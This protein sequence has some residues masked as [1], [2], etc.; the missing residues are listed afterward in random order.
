[1]AIA[2]GA[3]DADALR[4]LADAVLDVEVVRLALEVRAG[5]PHAVRRAVELAA[6]VLAAAAEECASRSADGA[7][8]SV[9]DTTGT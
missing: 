2:S 3:V 7:P 6:M 5:G 9:G 4:A 8:V 1:M